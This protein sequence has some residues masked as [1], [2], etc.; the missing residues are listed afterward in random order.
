MANYTRYSVRAG[1]NGKM[2]VDVPFGAIK[3]RGERN[4]V[5]AYAWSKLMGEDDLLR[6]DKNSKTREFLMRELRSRYSAKRDEVFDM[7]CSGV[8]YLPMHNVEK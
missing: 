6:V 2:I 4:A 3:L 7:F 8:R 1:M 5:L